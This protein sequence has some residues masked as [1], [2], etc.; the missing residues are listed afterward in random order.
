MHRVLESH[1]NSFA[2]SNGFE[3]EKQSEQFEKF[4]NFSIISSKVSTNYDIE[5]VTTSEGDDG[6]DGI[7][8]II[9]EEVIVSKEDA[10]KIFA[11]EKR[12]HDVDV[13]CIQA[14]TSESVDLGDFLKFKESV[15]RFVNGGDYNVPDETQ[16][17]AREVFDVV[18][19]SVPK[20]KNGRPSIV[21]R[22]VT[23]GIY[24]EPAALEVAK[25]EFEGQL[26]A[27]GLFNSIDIKFIDRDELI[28][29]WVSTYSGISARLEMFS[30][31]PMPSIS[32]IEEAYLGVVK[33]KE[34]VAK[35]LTSSDGTLRTHVF[36][37]N[38]RSFLGSDNPINHSIAQTINSG[39]ISTRFPVLNNGITIV[40][41]N[42]V[43]QNNTLYIENFQIVNG[44][45]TSN[46]LFDNRETLT[47]STMVT[48]KVVETSN[49]DVFSELVR[50]TNSQSK[51][52]E[53]QFFS[54][55]PVV[56]AVELY[57]NTFDNESRL[58]FER[59]DRQYIGEEI[60]ALRIFSV[61]SAAKCVCAMFCQRPDISFK[62]PKAMYDEL[63]RVIFADG[64]KES[65]FYASCLSYYRFNLFVSSNAISQ[66]KRR[67]KWHVLPIVRAIICGKDLPLLNS[68]AAEIAA[69]KL[70]DVMSHR[71]QALEAFSK[72]IAIVDSFG[73]ITDDRLKRQ[74]ILL[75][76]LTKVS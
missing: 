16:R 5:D 38:V 67:Y 48:L 1:L 64:N 61:H 27:L 70:I 62:Y 63:G 10:A 65:V 60:P 7:A 28:A 43:S 45:Q 8:I 15:L 42:V 24:Q 36:E 73:E 18:I 72:A 12:N 20:V 41:P 40:S 68:R 74:A 2:K 30:I 71:D 32:G 54:L 47:D 59:R 34:F 51:I 46:V 11:T 33:A 39:D 57:F 17:A 6:T 4:V 19:E 25:R 76:M 58:Y 9:D 13:V 3:S 44:C 37:E 69:T 50:A 22:Y 52:E 35:I 55:K 53:T 26:S 29:L 31:A 75:E 66:N 21:I 23:A 14:K 56:R 49:E